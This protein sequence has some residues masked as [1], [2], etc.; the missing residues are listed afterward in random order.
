LFV[1]DGI[2]PSLLG[3][4]KPNEASEMRAYDVPKEVGNVRNN[5]E[6]L[7]KKIN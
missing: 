6:E 7:L 4:L 2:S 5:N 3:L 1:Q